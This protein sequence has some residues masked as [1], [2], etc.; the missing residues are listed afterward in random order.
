M[1]PGNGG[2][3]RSEEGHIPATGGANDLSSMRTRQRGQRS[4]GL[5]VQVMM[6]L[7]WRD[8]SQIM[9]SRVYLALFFAPLLMVLL[10]GFLVLSVTAM[11][12]AIKLATPPEQGSPLGHDRIVVLVPA[13]PSPDEK[14]VLD[15]TLAY[16]KGAHPAAPEE[17]RLFQ[18]FL[19]FLK[20]A[21]N[22]PEAASPTDAGSPSMAGASV[23][24]LPEDGAVALP[25]PVAPLKSEP[26]GVPGI[27]SGSNPPDSGTEPIS[28]NDS[29]QMDIRT[30]DTWETIR[31]QVPDTY[32]LG[33]R[34]EVT[35]EGMVRYSV[36][37]DPG[38]LFSRLMQKRV[39]ALIEEYNLELGRATPTAHLALTLTEQP[40]STPDLWLVRSLLL[41]AGLSFAFLYHSVGVQSVAGV[42]AGERDSRTLDVLVSLPITRRQ[43]LYGKV[44]GLLCTTALPT[45]FW[46]SVVWV[47]AWLFYGIRLPMGPLWLLQLALLVALMSSGC[48]VSAASPDLVTARNR[49]GMTNLVTMTAGGLLFGLP[50]SVWP[51][52]LHPVSL[53][54]SVTQ[55]GWTAW[56]ILLVLTSGLLM[57]AAAILELGLRGWMKL[58]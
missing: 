13:H 46:S 45:I 31:S 43:I 12:V 15:R 47:P 16:L 7:A 5:G 37:S 30:S 4:T 38:L 53:L 8:A 55:G 42:L 22:A 50:A 23:G 36:A 32:D 9:G 39:E 3:N 48:A 52:G 19:T 54:L 6:R 41:M 17:A 33:L 24:T 20:E 25:P 29:L 58:R 1:S 34:L 26:G 35:P 40:T 14:A 57:I 11:L 27:R 18:R 21:R 51:P 28:G 2:Q 56:A 10:L 49:L 44:L